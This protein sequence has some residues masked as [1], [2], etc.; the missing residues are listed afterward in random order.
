MAAEP[1]SSWQWLADR[2]R[3]Y[4]WYNYKQLLWLTQSKPA[5]THVLVAGS[6][7]SGTNMLMGI[8]ERSRQTDVYH[9]SDSRAFHEFQM[10]DLET[11]RALTRA[12]NS[13][14]FVI[15]SLCE[16]DQL[17]EI[18]TALGPTKTIW[19]Y[20]HY[21]DMV[22]S[23]R[24]QFSS[25]PGAVAR[26]V[27]RSQLDDWRVRGLTDDIHATLVEHMDEHATENTAIALF[28]Y[29]RN[30]L[31]YEMALDRDPNVLL[32]NYERLVTEPAREAKR[33]FDFIGLEYSPSVHAQVFSTSIKK[34]PAPTAL[35]EST[36]ALCDRL[37]DRLDQSLNGPV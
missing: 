7:R 5:K 18:S 24:R 25:L 35:A 34:N 8:L 10:R 33:V 14:F 26:M 37:F 29:A 23:G 16:L 15:K 20:R 21:T 36:R 30:Q 22:N 3:K 9:E 17:K 19:I 1:I 4:L 28:W 32:V 27:Q 6:Q 31:F 11:I 13:P 2:T 12:N